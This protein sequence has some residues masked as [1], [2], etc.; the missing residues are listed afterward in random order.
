MELY[1]RKVALLKAKLTKFVDSIDQKKRVAEME[2]II[3]KSIF[4]TV[5]SY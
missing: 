3:Y 2:H 1:W 5:F 4:F